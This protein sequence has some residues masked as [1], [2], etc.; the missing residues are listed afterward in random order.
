[1]AAPFFLNM[2]LSLPEDGHLHMHSGGGFR[3]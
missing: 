3:V 2:L 1:M